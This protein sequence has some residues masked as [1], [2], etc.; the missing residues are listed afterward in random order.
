[1]KLQYL[2]AVTMAVGVA[3]MAGP[4]GA[5]TITDCGPT[6]CYRYDNAQTAV[7][8][9]GL[10]TRVGDDMQFFPASFL[11]LS[12]GTGFATAGP[13]NF[14]F[15]RVWTTGGQEI[16]SLAVN[17]EFDYEIVNGGNV[18]ASLY[19]QARSNHV[20]S[21]GISQLWNL[22]TISGDS[23]GAQIAS[24]SGTLLPAAS[25]VQKADDMTVS[26]QDTLRAYAASGQLAWIQKKFTLVT[27]VVVPVPAAL[28][29]L[30]SGLGLLGVVRRRQSV[31]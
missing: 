10:P 17:E 31:L 19:M 7:A 18:R 23:G 3:G 4:A 27:Q 14:I 5:A 1:M 21:D 12:N 2:M 11:A 15:D 28:W 20:S 29:L 26:I 9:T 22:A 24:L 13:A 6:V 25:F 30:G 8:W 16:A